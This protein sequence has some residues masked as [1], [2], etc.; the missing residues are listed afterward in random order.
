MANELPT[1]GFFRE[2]KPACRL[3]V[4]DLQ[5]TERAR[6]FGLRH[7]CEFIPQKFV[8]LGRAPKRIRELTNR[9]WF[10]RTEE[11]RLGYLGKIHPKTRLKASKPKRLS[12][13]GP[14][15]LNLTNCLLDFI[16][17]RV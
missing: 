11:Q 6:H 10:L 1:L 3:N 7:L 16:R 13:S 4:I 8:T 17:D 5:L 9:E 12:V 2:L 14:L 15:V